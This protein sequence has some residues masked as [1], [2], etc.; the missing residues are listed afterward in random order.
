MQD[1]IYLLRVEHDKHTE[2]FFSHG[3]LKKKKKREIIKLSERKKR[4]DTKGNITS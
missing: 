3:G 2:N 1:L 4:G